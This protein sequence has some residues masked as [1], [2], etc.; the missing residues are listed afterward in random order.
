MFNFSCFF[1]II[2]IFIYRQLK[3]TMENDKEQ[4]FQELLEYLFGE[5]S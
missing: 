4:L 5:L 3:M 2:D 1:G